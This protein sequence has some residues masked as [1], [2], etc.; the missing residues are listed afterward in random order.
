[1][2]ACI[3]EVS[4]GSDHSGGGR[5]VLLAL[6]IFAFASFLTSRSTL[7]DRDE[8]RFAQATDEM[9]RSGNWLVPT[10]NGAVRADKPV[11]VYWLMAL[12]MKVFG[13]SAWSARFWS[14]VCLALSALLAFV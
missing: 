5:A 4:R 3:D 12:P 7:F 9:L 8:P 13:A 1:M 14:P 10:F 11:L 6:A 2:S